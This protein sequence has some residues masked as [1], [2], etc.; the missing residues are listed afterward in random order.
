MGK[1]RLIHLYQAGVRRARDHPTRQSRQG[2]GAGRRVLVSLGNAFFH[3]PYWG[4]NEVLW[5]GGMVTFLNNLDPD[6][7][8]F[9]LPGY[10]RVVQTGQADRQGLRRRDPSREILRPGRQSRGRPGTGRALHLHGGPSRGEAG[11]DFEGAGDEGWRGVCEG[12]EGGVWGDE[13]L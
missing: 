4:Y 11:D 9:D 2:T 13:V 5:H 1:T 3:T 6:A 10:G 8:P 7:Y 12:V